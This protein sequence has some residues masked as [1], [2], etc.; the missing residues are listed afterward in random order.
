MYTRAFVRVYAC[1][2]A[3]AYL[4]ACARVRACKLLTNSLSF[5]L[6]GNINKKILHTVADHAIPLSKE[7]VK[8]AHD[9]GKALRVCLYCI[10][11]MHVFVQDFSY[12]THSTP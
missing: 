9:A 5:A 1:L 2:Y 6:A 10:V 12:T 7:G 3:C 8:Q 4:R 11:Y